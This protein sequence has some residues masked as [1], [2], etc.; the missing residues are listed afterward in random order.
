MQ[1]DQQ[2]NDMQ[3][4]ELLAEDVRNARN[5]LGEVVTD[6]ESRISEIRRTFLA[7]MRE[8]VCALNDAQDALRAAVKQSS[9]D[10]W[11]RRRTRT[12]HG[13]RFGW[14]KGKGKITWTD[15]AKV[16]ERIKQEFGDQADTYV[17]SK[18]SVVKDAIQQLDAKRLKKLGITVTDGSDE[19]VIKDT[20]GELDK[21][22]DML[23]GDAM[24]DE[25]E[26]A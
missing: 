7:P 22:I 10:L 21:L 14:M 26:G 25:Q 8:R 5:A 19:V 4:L 6:L 9:D 3:Q 1:T 16:I 23:M 12:A 15:E 17:R 24:A 20:A 2:P 18:E 13:I 11:K